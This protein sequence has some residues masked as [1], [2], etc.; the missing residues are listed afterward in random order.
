MRNPYLLYDQT[1]TSGGSLDTGALP[2][3]RFSSLLL[4]AVAAG[5]AAPT[6]WVASEVGV[7][8]IAN[9][10][11]TFTAP[12]IGASVG[13]GLGPGCTVALPVPQRTKVA[14]TAGAASTV[15]LKV[16]GVE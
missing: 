3:G 10:L 7:D 13:A 2:T 16:Y 15:R 9:A 6:A 4:V 5:A 11:A 14:I 1:S 8:G 12:G